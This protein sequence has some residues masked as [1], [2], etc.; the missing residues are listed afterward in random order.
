MAAEGN[1]ASNGWPLGL[2]STRLR[3]METIQAAPAET[4]SLRIRSSSFSSFSSSNLD[5]EVKICSSSSR[6]SCQQHPFF[7]DRSVPTGP[8]NWNQTREWRADMSHGICIRLLAG[9]LEKM[10]RSK[11]KSRQ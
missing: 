7:Q 4:Y 3:V 2:M 1:E 9:T 8:A 6:C 5:T 11:S 10:S